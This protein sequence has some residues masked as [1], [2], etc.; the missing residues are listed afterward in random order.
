MTLVRTP[1]ERAGQR[2][3]GWPVSDIQRYCA[4]QRV[5]G[6]SWQVNDRLRLGTR[7]LALLLVALTTVLPGWAC[8]T[9]VVRQAGA[10]GGLRGIHD[11]IGQVPTIES[12]VWTPSW[13]RSRGEG[14]I[15]SDAN[16]AYWAA[17]VVANPLITWTISGTYPAARYASI[18]LIWPTEQR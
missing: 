11:G 7:L 1:R 8:H 14:L 4:T 12:A 16:A 13:V 10:R 17:L 15:G 5:H 3:K 9:G 2:L 6:E 18:K